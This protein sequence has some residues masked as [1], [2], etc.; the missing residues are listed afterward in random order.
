MEQYILEG[1]ISVKAAILSNKR[2]IY[3][4]LI[5]SSKKDKD[6][7]YILAKAYE[8]NI[9]VIKTNREEIDLLAKGNTHGGLIAYVGPISTYSIN[10]LNETNK[11]VALI[12]GIEDPFNFAYILRSLYAAG[13]EGII[14]S[15]RNWSN[16]ATTLAK[17]SAGASE[18]INMYIYESPNEVIAALK[19]CSL[20]LICAYRKDATSLFSYHFPTK[21]C[22]AIGGE[23]RGLSK[24]FIEHS[25]TNIYIPYAN[26]FRNALSGASASAVIAFEYFRQMS[27]KM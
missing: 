13:V 14:V 15:S 19:S 22:I 18:Y 21:C 12:E 24:I 27:N 16:A 6:S 3:K 20:P 4:V 23:L 8:R 10:E 25:S 9:E 1:N 26:D 5:D 17:S 7:N 11:F 2:T